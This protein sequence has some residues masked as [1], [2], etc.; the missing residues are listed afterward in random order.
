MAPLNGQPLNELNFAL[1]GWLRWYRLRRAALWSIHGLVLGLLLAL[2][3]SAVALSQARLLMAEFLQLAAVVV[4]GSL[5]VAAA[6]A[7][8]WP[9]ARLRAARF[10]DRRFGLLERVSTALEFTGLGDETTE[11]AGLQLQDAVTAARQVDVRARLPIRLDWR[12][13]LL[14]AALGAGLFLLGLRGEPYFQTAA[15]TRLVQQAISAET[16]R[17]EELHRQIAAS[18][19]LSSQAQESLAAPLQEA[20]RQLEQAQTL[21]QAISALNSAQGQLE[22]LAPAQLQEQVRALQEVGRLAGQQAGSPLQSAGQALADADPPGAAEALRSLDPSRLDQAQSDTLA[23]QLEEAAEILG[24]LDPGLASQRLAGQLAEAAEAL[25]SGELTS[26]QAQ[27][28]QAAET[29]TALDRQI[30]Q[31]QVAQQAAAQAQAAQQRLAQA[32]SEALALCSGPECGVGSFQDQSAGQAPG[33]GTSSQPGQGSAAAGAG[34]GEGG[35]SQAGEEVGVAPID[36]GNGPGDGGLRAYE[37][38]YAPERLGGTGGIDVPLPGSDQPGDQLRGEGAVAPGAAGP[39]RVPYVEVYPSYA[40]AY[41]QAIASG[42][43]PIW[44]RS[45]VR[46]YFRG[47]EP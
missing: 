10:F 33:T 38:I 22:T 45:I 16:A 15:R 34:R 28:R 12:E 14:A 23:G 8:L 13:I 39:G 37:Q 40:Q 11:L 5:L 17:I 47:L 46:Q 19:S 1:A 2:V 44:L 20:A 27:L 30:Q 4:L 42:Q 24:E 36:M 3:V 18:Q 29:L 9:V 26:A 32:Q 35:Q 25:R 31:G 6:A 21:E 41:R 43:V 7:Y